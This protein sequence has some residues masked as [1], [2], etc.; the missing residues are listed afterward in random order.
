MARIDPN[1]GMVLAAGGL[2]LRAA[3]LAIALGLGGAALIAFLE[4]PDPYV[5]EAADTESGP[6]PVELR[7]PCR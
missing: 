6:L 3:L 5:V 4:G 7:D 2:G 1:T